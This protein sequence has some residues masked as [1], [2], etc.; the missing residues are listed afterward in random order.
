MEIKVD[1][2]TGKTTFITYIGGDAYNAPAIWRSEQ[3]TTT[4]NGYYFLF[5]DYL[6]SIL[7]ISD[8]NGLIKEKRHFDAWG[9]VVKL[10]DGFNTALQKFEILDRGYTG[11]EHLLGLKLIHMNGRLYD[12]V[13]HRFL[14]PDNYIQDPYNTQNYNRYGYVLNNPLMFTDPSGEFIFETAAAIYY[15]ISGVIILAAAIWGTADSGWYGHASDP[16]PTPTANQNNSSNISSNGMVIRDG[17]YILVNPFGIFQNALMRS[18]TSSQI[19]YA[20][21]GPSDWIDNG[22]NLRGKTNQDLERPDIV[23]LNSSDALEQ[24]MKW[25]KYMNKSGDNYDLA[26]IFDYRTIPKK[27]WFMELFGDF[28]GTDSFEVGGKINGYG[29]SLFVIDRHF[30][31]NRSNNVVGYIVDYEEHANNTD[32]Y[33]IR[34][35]TREYPS[36]TRFTLKFSNEKSFDDAKKYIGL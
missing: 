27:H 24:V 29:A 34:V 25:L 13:V 15:I 19:A 14:A 26:E 3:G 12:P 36:Y 5:R 18:S 28:I 23:N 16:P 9:N 11:H 20:T 35:K 22:N 31:V 21:T 10:T 33:Q 2:T 7:M 4:I 32:I 1:Q 6:G 30:F 8:K 17:G